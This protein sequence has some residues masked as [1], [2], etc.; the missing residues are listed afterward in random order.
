MVAD[1]LATREPAAPLD[2]EALVAGEPRGGPAAVAAARPAQPRV[3]LQ[4]PDGA[5]RSSSPATAACWARAARSCAP[6]A[7]S[8]P[9]SSARPSAPSPWSARSPSPVG[10]A[11]VSDD[12]R[13]RRPA[14]RGRGRAAGTRGRRLLR[15]RRHPDRRLLRR[16]RVPRAADRRRVGA[17]GARRHPRRVLQR[18]P[19]RPR[20]VPP[21]GGRARSRCPVARSTEHRRPGRELFRTRIAGK[22][23]PDARRLV[24]AHHSAGHTVA[25]ASSATRFQA[26]EAAADL[27]IEHVLVTEI[28]DEDGILTG[29]VRGPILWGPGKAQAVR[30]VR[31][32]ARRRPRRSPTPTATVARTCPTSRTVGRPRPLNPD[33]GLTAEAQERGWPV[34]RL[35]RVNRLTPDHRGPHGRLHG[36]AGRR[37]RGRAGAGAAQPGPAYGARRWPPRSPRSCRWPLAGVKLD[38]VGQDNLWSARARGLPLQPPEPARRAGAGLAAAQGLHRGRQEGAGHR[39]DASRRWAGSPTSRTSTAPTPPRPRRPS[40]RRWTRCATARRW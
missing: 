13:D 27:D 34:H 31:R 22:V 24:A 2:E 17:A 19:A 33:L 3:D 36:R 15:L 32:R 28:E 26:A 5:A 11:G 8:S 37:R 1:R 23:Y 30:G 29:K 16:D 35:T 9:P 21:D 12:R 6:P 40:R 38:V 18:L 4:G 20:R 7:R 10:G 39:P 25:L 14:R